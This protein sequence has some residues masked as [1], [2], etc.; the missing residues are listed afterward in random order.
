MLKEVRRS[1]KLLQTLVKR[2]SNTEKRLMVVEGTINKVT[3]TSCSSGIESTPT[4]SKR[5]KHDVPQVVRVSKNSLV[6]TLVVHICYV[7]SLFLSSVR[8]GENMDY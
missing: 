6:S 2:V 4:R 7:L 1:N 5:A 3:C 8:Q